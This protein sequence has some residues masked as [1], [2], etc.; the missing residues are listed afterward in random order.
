MVH[1][2]NNPIAGIL[3]LTMLIRRIIEEDSNAHKETNR[4]IQY[5]TLMETETRRISRIVSNLLSF[6]RHSKIEIK[7][8]NLNRLLEK[9]LMLNSNLF[10]INDI[11]VN[12]SL[13]ANLP[14]IV[15]SEDQLQQVIMNFISNAAEAMEGNSES[16]FNIK[17]K[18]LQKDKK[19]K[20]IFEDNG[21]G[22]EKEHLARLFEPFFT[23][24]K[25]G[26]GAY[27]KYPLGERME[28][29]EMRKNSGD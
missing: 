18:Y 1:E 29:S 9:T 13:E 4:F 24:K 10:K 25:R 27:H 23:T 26:K 2:I 8:L 14:D 28:Y 5:L 19:I 20:I 21:I 3:N 11:R 6:S 15:G 17:T 12:S 16:V 7:K 22:I